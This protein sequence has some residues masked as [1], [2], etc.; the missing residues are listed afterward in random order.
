LEEGIT[1]S[2]ARVTALQILT[3]YGLRDAFVGSLLSS[4]LRD[5]VLDRRDRALV[6]GLVQGTVRMKL[7]LDWA[8][9]EFSNRPLESLDPGV[10]WSLRLSAFQLMF[11]DVPDYAAVDLAARATAEVVGQHAVGFVNAVMR[12]FAKGYEAVPY[13]SAEDDPAG[14]LEV[15]QSHPRW[16]VEMWIREL[17]FDKAASICEADNAEPL[18]SL[19]ANLRRTC[20]GRERKAWGR[21]GG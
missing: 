2:R 3:D 7:T 6:T 9:K 4:R 21:P 12:A 16:V 18:V 19:R 14:Y 1:G 11:T 8:L 15:R 17:G 13:P 5:S 10:L 20:R